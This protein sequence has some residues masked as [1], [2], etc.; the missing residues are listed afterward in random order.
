[1]NQA[2]MMPAPGDDEERR[3]AEAGT[4]VEGE[5][6]GG[7]GRAE[8]EGAAQVEG[9]ARR[10]VTRVRN[11]EDD[12]RGGEE[13]ERHSIPEHGRPSP[14]VDEDATDD[15]P[16]HEG[17]RE[18]H[19]EPADDPASLAFRKRKGGE[20]GSA[21]QQER[22]PR[23]L[24]D[25]GGEEPA[26][27]RRES[28]QDERGRAPDEAGHEHALVAHDVRETAESRDEGR[29]G[30]DVADD[31][32]LDGRDVVVERGG[33]G[34]ERDIDRGIERSRG[35]AEGNDEERE[36]GAGRPGL[37]RR[38]F[39]G[40]QHSS[41]SAILGP[42]PARGRIHRPPGNAAT[43]TVPGVAPGPPRFRSCADPR[44]HRCRPGRLDAEHPARTA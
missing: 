31:H 37:A 13:D 9:F 10:R 35:Y 22:V 3:P 19:G 42:P 4:L 17:G 12:Q 26:E 40:F 38:C 18:P 28:A 43:D 24:E 29:V 14:E 32:P 7:E 41:P 44:T 16:E 34:G 1:M 21:A 6:G 5:E 15:R 36:P 20:G 2:A 25:A 8:P 33:D 11:Q 23:S 30:E 39:A 27:A